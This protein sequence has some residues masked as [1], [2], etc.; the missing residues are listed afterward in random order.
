MSTP[1]AANG[2]PLNPTRKPLPLS[3]SQESQVREL[4]HKRVRNKCA[5][6]VRGIHPRKHCSQKRSVIDQCSS[7]F[8]ACCSTKT[9]TAT[10]SCR[11]QQKAMNSCMNHYATRAE[12]D[13]AREEWF[14]TMDSRRE[15]RLA[16][17][18]KR[19][20]DE[21]FWKD[22]WDKEKKTTELPAPR[23]REDEKKK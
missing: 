4:Y 3:A 9:F 8:A 6:Q 10:F 18:K 11:P 20:E 1:T 22:W 17:E 23:L 5:E 16:K 21:K 12:E 2:A 19:V 13:A 7:D 15:E 14:A